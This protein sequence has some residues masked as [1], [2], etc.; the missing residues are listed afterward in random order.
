MIFFKWYWRNNLDAKISKEPFCFYRRLRQVNPS[1]YMFYINFGK[2]K[3]VGASPEMLV[4]IADD[5]VYTYP[6]AELKTKRC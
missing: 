2:R 4:K 1:P 5:T 3:L 6:I